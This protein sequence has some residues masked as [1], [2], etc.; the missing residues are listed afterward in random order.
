VGALVAFKGAGADQPAPDPNR[1]SATDTF[2][3][4][5]T[6]EGGGN[7]PPVVSSASV[8]PSSP[9]TDDL[10]TATVDASDPDGD[11]LTYSYQ[12]RK[13]GTDIS[14]ANAQTLDLALA[15]KGDKGDAV[16]VRVTASDGSATSD[17]VTSPEVTVANSLPA[18]NQDLGGQTSTE[19]EAVSLSAGATD[20]DGDALTFAASGLPPG[21]SIAASTGLIAGTIAAGAAAQSPYNVAVTV[22][23]GAGPEATDTFTWSV[24]A[25][26]T[27]PAQPAVAGI[28]PVYNTAGTTRNSHAVPLP[29]NIAPE[30]LLIVVFPY[31]GGGGASWPVG[32][33]EI[34]DQ[35]N[36]THG[37][38]IAYR[39]ADGGEGPTVTVT[40]E[41]EQ[42]VGFAYRITGSHGTTP[43][44]IIS[45]VGSSTTPDPPAL[46]SSW[47]SAN[48]LWI[49]AYG[50]NGGPDKPGPSFP[51]TDHKLWAR[52]GGSGA[53]GG[54][55]A[56][57]VIAAATLNPDPFHNS[58]DRPWV[59]ATI[60][61]RPA[62]S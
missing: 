58:A 62:S 9:R 46:T 14:G 44:E 18:F 10:V 13:N 29:D 45:A 26:I 39:I 53:S 27:S 43:P 2:S 23:D 20:P 15:G 42:A 34:L 36:S 55:L 24:Q 16:S 3:W 6:Q 5:V 41:A 61:V 30:D 7:S 28:G 47:G 32:W 8:T 12:W 50:I 33:T 48:T 56:S 22:G 19:G 59:A 37:L 35:P 21:L 17:P 54:A 51:L 38:A 60:A 25:P 1:G 52:T 31:D 4:T 40:T 11:Q 57:Q 49:A